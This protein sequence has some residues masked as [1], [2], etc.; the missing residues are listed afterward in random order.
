MLRRHSHMS[1]SKSSAPCSNLLSYILTSHR[2]RGE[3]AEE[4]GIDE[5]TGKILVRIDPRY[6][7]PVEVE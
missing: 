3:G 1:M 2:W 6:I 4:E 7:R 5:K